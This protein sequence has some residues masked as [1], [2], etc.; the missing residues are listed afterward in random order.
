MALKALIITYYWPPAGGSGVQ[1][2]LYFVKYLRNN[3]IEPVVFTVEN[4]KYPITDKSLESQIPE[5]IEI[6]R[7]KIWE[8][9]Q[10]ISKNKNAGSGFLP[11]K[12]SFIQ[13]FKQYIRANYFIPDARKFWIKPSSKKIIQ[14]L[15]KNPVDWI[16][17]T[18]P[19]HSV[20]LIG[21]KVKEKTGVKWLADF[22]DPWTEIDYFHHL[23]L[24]QK[25]KARHLELETE[26]LQKADQVTV[27]S[28]TM[29]SQFEKI[30]PNCTVIT[31]GFDDAHVSEA[32]E[33]DKPFTI[34]HIGMLNADRN[35]I[36]LWEVLAEMLEENEDFEASVQI[37]LVGHIADEVRNSIRLYNLER[38]VN[39]TQ[40]LPSHAVAAFQMK[41]QVLLLIINNVPSAKTIITGKVYEYL[42]AKRPILAIAPTDGD[43][44]DIID[45]TQSGIVVDFDDKEGL[46]QGLD[47]YFKHFM[48]NQLKIES[49]NVEQF[50]RK[51]LTLQLA[52]LLKKA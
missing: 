23:P 17:T 32:P 41:S 37:N 38:F 31:N 46:K 19:P 51:N 47:L 52:E 35:P 28:N 11:E 42:R 7:Q 27:V 12:P 16:I 33:M 4:P 36:L 18:G 39:Y 8:P 29:K 40:Y 24:T 25:S 45:H 3:G 26:V 2:W 22:R 43:L 50:H 15:Q 13:K 21:K 30:N 49:K 10:M 34:T 1:R 5:G 44:A 14:Y 48:K 20:H 9:G 6:V